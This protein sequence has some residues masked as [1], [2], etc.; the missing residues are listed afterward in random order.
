MNYLDKIQSLNVVSIKVK[1]LKKEGKIIV[2]T[3]GS[4]DIVHAGHLRS[5][6][7][8]KDQGDILIVGINSD[9]SVKKYKSQNRPIINQRFRS[10]MIAALEFVD[11]VFIFDELNP[12]EFLKEIKPD[13]HTNSVD[14]GEDC[15]EREIVE[16]NGGRI[17]LLQKVSDLS[18]TKII[19]KIL[20]V[21]KKEGY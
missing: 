21:Y 9:Q 5:L 19:K 18:T 6:K 12:I 8:S 14:Y 7:E 11:Y 16:S 17:Y 2:T 15:V 20:D 1:K 13:V 4:Y 3:N 10:E